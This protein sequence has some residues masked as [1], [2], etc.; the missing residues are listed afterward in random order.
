MNNDELTEAI[1]NIVDECD[2]VYV[3]DDEIT[4]NGTLAYQEIVEIAE[5][6][7]KEGRV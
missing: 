4:L 5:L 1:E 3:W 6:L 2:F 7:K